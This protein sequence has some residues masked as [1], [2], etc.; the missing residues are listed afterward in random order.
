MSRERLPDRRAAEAIE[1]EHVWRG[2]HG[3]VEETMLITVGRYDDGRVAEVF[4]DYPPRE[5][6]RKKSDRTRDLGHDIA[7]LISIAL[8]HGAPLDVLRDAVGR[9]DLNLMGTVKLVPHTIVGT[10]LDALEAEAK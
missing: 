7:V 9:S 6:E 2:P 3:D 4:I 1:I 8:Q 10:V 5:G